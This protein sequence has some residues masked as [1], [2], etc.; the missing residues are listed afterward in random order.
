MQCYG[1]PTFLTGNHSAPSNAQRLLPRYD[2]VLY[3]GLHHYLPVAG[4]GETF[5]GVAAMSGDTS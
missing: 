3:L 5:D 2:I 4:R 1:R